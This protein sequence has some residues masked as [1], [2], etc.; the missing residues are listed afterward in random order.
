[1][2]LKLN[3]SLIFIP[4][5][6][7]E[8]TDFFNIN[9]ECS[10]ENCSIFILVFIILFGTLLSIGIFLIIKRLRS[11]NSRI[12]VQVRAVKVKNIENDRKI[13]DDSVEFYDL[14]NNN[15]NFAHILKKL[16]Q[17]VPVYKTIEGVDES[18]RKNNSNLST[19]KP[20]ENEIYQV[21]LE[22]E[23]KAHMAEENL[24]FQNVQKNLM[25]KNDSGSSKSSKKNFFNEK[26]DHKAHMFADDSSIQF[27]QDSC[28]EMSIESPD[29][30]LNFEEKKM[31]IIDKYQPY[32][33]GD[34]NKKDR[35]NKQDGNLVNLTISKV[36]QTAEECNRLKTIVE[37]N[38]GMVDTVRGDNK[39]SVI[40]KN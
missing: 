38:E 14:M 5:L 31:E 35:D 29:Q 34:E 20:K 39:I 33:E 13:N 36:Q 27:E 2:I 1:M 24:I 4:V 8:E 26:L 18:N 11:R 6:L 15:K 9:A 25:L 37:E 19:A 22:N 16:P 17:E 28:Y 40:K 23:L 3:A 21:K 10:V 30:N 7:G 32:L 12:Y